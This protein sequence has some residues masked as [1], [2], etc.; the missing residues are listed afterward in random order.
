MTEFCRMIDLRGIGAAPVEIVATPAEC[1]ALARRFALVAVKRLS[2][3]IVLVA[4]GEKVA[5]SGRLQAAVVQACAVSGED[6]AVKIDEQIDLRFVPPAPEA[7]G[8]EI[9]LTA[10]QLDEIEYE[11]SAFDLGEALAQSLVLAIDPF[12]T[13]PNADRARQESGLLGAASSGPFA[14]LAALKGKPA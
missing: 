13:G 9:E 11:G 2:A 6:L 4:A 10:D 1:A 12:L 14:A 3:K 5:A 7:L 8:E